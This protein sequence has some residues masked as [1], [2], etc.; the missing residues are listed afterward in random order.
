MTW[1]LRDVLAGYRTTRVTATTLD[2]LLARGVAG[3]KTEALADPRFRAAALGRAI[4]T[5]ALYRRGE[6]APVAAGGLARLTDEDTHAW[7]AFA[8]DGTRRDRTVATR[9]ARTVLDW[10]R[11]PARMHV[12]AEATW[13]DSFAAALGF[14]SSGRVDEIG[15][16]AGPWREMRRNGP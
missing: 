15:G 6:E 2:A 5:R 1:P 3:P 4:V 10:A 12:H 8:A 7:A 14:H 13:A 16:V 11:V 9:L